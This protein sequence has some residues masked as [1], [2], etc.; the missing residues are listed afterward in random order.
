MRNRITNLFHLLGNV[1][2]ARK[3]MKASG[4]TPQTQI[5][6]HRG[7]QT[8]KL[9]LYRPGKTK[10]PAPLLIYFHGGGW[11]VGSRNLI[12]PFF[13]DQVKRGYALASISYT[14]AQKAPWPA[15]IEDAETAIKWL[16]THA[17]ALGID[18]DHIV[19]CGVSAGA[20]LALVAG[21]RNKGIANGIL[22]FYPP[23]D[24]SLL[25]K[26]G[27]IMKRALRILFGARLREVLEK[28]KQAS[29]IT[30]A[31]KD[32][33]PIYILHGTADHMVPH[34]QSE[35]FTKA[36]RDV[37]ADVTFVSLP[38]LVHADKRLNDPEHRPGM[39]AFLDRV[40]GRK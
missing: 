34:D 6:G 36:L 7:G 28:V 31:R 40:A 30:H 5:Y 9:D 17:D 37:G 26:K 2:N 21:L 24:F 16:R 11:V 8:L 29:P 15:Q 22:A 12:E 20:Q 3:A 25:V 14:L 1:R 18:A 23:T 10:A 27:Q 19:L 33:P 13:I 32:A 39:E 4:L 35:V 38:G